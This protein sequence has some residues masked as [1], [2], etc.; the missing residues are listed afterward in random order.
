[1]NFPVSRFLIARNNTRKVNRRGLLLISSFVLLLSQ[2]KKQ[3]RP[4]CI[5]PL[6]P[7]RFGK[8]FSGVSLNCQC[9]PAQLQ[10]HQS[11]F[12][13]SFHSLSCQRNEASAS[14]PR[15]SVCLLLTNNFWIHWPNP[16]QFES[17][18]GSHGYSALSHVVRHLRGLLLLHERQATGL[19]P[20]GSPQPERDA[21]NCINSLAQIQT[22]HQHSPA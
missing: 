13:F 14:A 4:A 19:T 9:F 2:W 20:S 12:F 16:R 17:R 10:K 22:W 6:F 1:M 21:R 15:A 7:H 3:K 18:W 11:S 5:F 8:T